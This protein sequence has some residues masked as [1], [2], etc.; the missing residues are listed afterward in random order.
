MLDKLIKEAVVIVAGKQSGEIIEF[1]DRNR[2]INE[3]LIAKKMDITVNQVRNILY[4]LSDKGLVSSTRKKDK[5]KGWYTYFWKVETLKALEFFRDILIKRIEQISFQIKSRET[6]DFYICE[7]C[8][9][10]FSEE[11]ALLYDFTCND[12]GGIFS[13]KD[14][15]SVLNEFSRN[16][17]KLRRKLKLVN[18]E[19][20]KEKEKIEKKRIKEIRKEE[21]EKQKKRA[22]K[23]KLL[24]KKS[25]TKKITKK[26]K[27]VK[28]PK[29]RMVKI[30]TKAKK[31]VVKKKPLKKGKP[32]KKASVRKL[33]ISSAKKKVVKKKP[34]KKKAVKK[35]KAK[36]KIVK[37][38]VVKKK[39]KKSLKRKVTKKK[40]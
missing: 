8:N 9:I 30:K 40:K 7:R 35:I 17:D 18:Q 28:K 12:C 20:N 4:R 36:K 23:R 38:K 15:T 10:E 24:K 31:K 11:N 33:K 1:L 13:A 5:K 2:Y 37:K 32:K 19:I 29:K 3:F 16:L 25:K 39:K 27:L 34:V 6:K 14:N 26:K 21:K 22:A